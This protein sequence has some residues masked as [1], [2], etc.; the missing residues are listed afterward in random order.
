MNRDL[1]ARHGLQGDNEFLDVASGEIERG[2]EGC[3]AS[4]VRMT[5]VQQVLGDFPPINGRRLVIGNRHGVECLDCS[6]VS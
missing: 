2:K 3:F 6:L 5:G 4:V 1:P